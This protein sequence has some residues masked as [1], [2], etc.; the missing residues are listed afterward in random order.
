MAFTDFGKY[1]RILG[2]FRLLVWHQ[3][4]EVNKINDWH[5]LLIQSRVP[6]YSVDD[7]P[8]EVGT[9]APIQYKDNI[10]PV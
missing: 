2:R 4:G 6:T 5:Q 9:R 1:N 8:N 10:L 3:A 7:A